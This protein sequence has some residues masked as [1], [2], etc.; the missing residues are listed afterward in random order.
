[1]DSMALTWN[2]ITFIVTM[3]LFWP[4]WGHQY[5]ILSTSDTQDR[6]LS[7]TKG[8]YKNL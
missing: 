6:I 8:G 2:T 1:M 5:F 4:T 3:V 7:D